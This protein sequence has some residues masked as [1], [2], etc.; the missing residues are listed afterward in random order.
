MNGPLNDFWEF[1]IVS[2]IWTSIHTINPPTPRFVFAYTSFTIDT[3]EY[4]AIFGGSL[5]TYDS[6]HLF[7]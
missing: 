2:M 4:F 1:D 6:N 7:M 5:P 3:Y